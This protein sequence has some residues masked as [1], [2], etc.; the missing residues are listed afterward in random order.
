MLIADIYDPPT[1]QGSAEE[2][3]VSNAKDFYDELRRIIFDTKVVISPLKTVK[4][5]GKGTTGAWGLAELL[6]VAFKIA[7]ES[8]GWQPLQSPGA[9]SPQSL[10]DWF[11]S[12]PSGR[13]YGAEKIGLGLEIQFG[14]NY[15]FNED[16]KRLSEANLAGY[17][18]AGVSIVASD[19]LAEYKADRGACFS[20]AKS[21]LDRHLE[22]LY[23]AQ[24]RRFSPMMIIGIENDSFNDDPCGYFE[25]TPVK[26]LR[27]ERNVIESRPETTITNKDSK[28]IISRRE[29]AGIKQGLN[30][31]PH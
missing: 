1:P 12:K 24:A 7:L 4:G 11:K 16:I 2:H 3:I 30:S 6:N 26:I 22:S 15:Q 21:K 25:I 9:E 17:T 31:F 5:Q 18:I 29:K 20:D 28:I 27:N 23:S 8:C 13:K 19:K 14:N 10:I